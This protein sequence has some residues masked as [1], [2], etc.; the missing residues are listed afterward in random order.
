M[1]E[2]GKEKR[3]KKKMVRGKE[4]RRKL[5]CKIVQFLYFPLHFSLTFPIRC[6]QKS[7]FLSTP[8]H[9]EKWFL[10]SLSTQ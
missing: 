7:S 8:E 10:Q 6:A 4:I 5:V 3:D 9:P 1:E 2:N